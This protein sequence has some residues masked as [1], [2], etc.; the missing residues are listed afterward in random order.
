MFNPLQPSRLHLIS[1]VPYPD[2]PVVAGGDKDVFE[3]MGCQTP[4]APLSVSVDHGVGGRVLLSHLYDLAIFGAHQDFT[5]DHQDRGDESEGLGKGF[6]LSVTEL[7]ME[8]GARDRTF[9]LQ[10]DRTFST[11]WP[12]SS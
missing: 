1:Q 9:P 12:V 3:G 6:T 10:T 4:D 11:G 7:H 8:E 5:L 2:G